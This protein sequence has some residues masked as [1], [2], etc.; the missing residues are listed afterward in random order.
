MARRCNG[1][2]ARAYA[3][4]AESTHPTRC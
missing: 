3:W 2:S 4:L 1:L